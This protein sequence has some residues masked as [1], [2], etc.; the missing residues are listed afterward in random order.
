MMAYYNAEMQY[1][2]D[3]MNG[4][5]ATPP[6]PD[7]LLRYAKDYYV[8]VS[9]LDVNFAVAAGAAWTGWVAAE[10][11][12][13]TTR[14]NAIINAEHQLGEDLSDAA[15]DLAEKQIAAEDS[16]AADMIDIDADYSIAVTGKQAEIEG[17]IADAEEALERAEHAAGEIAAKAVNLAEKDREHDYADADEA[18]AEALALE[19]EDLTND[20]AAEEETRQNSYATADAGWLAAEA[21]AQIASTSIAAGATSTLIN[22][23]ASAEVTYITAA[24]PLMTTV[25]LLR[26]RTAMTCFRDT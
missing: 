18:R 12:A 13:D 21:A 17:D 4:L 24:A 6:N 19:N 5:P 25:S 8:D 15:Q 3:M 10:R 9:A 20:L 7:D 16:Y 1:Y 2:E 23:L 14:D 11:A 26:F 22:D